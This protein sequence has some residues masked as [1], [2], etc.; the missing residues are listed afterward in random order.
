[1][2]RGAHRDIVVLNAAAGLMVAGRADTMQD[3]VV[4]AAGAIDDGRAASTLAALVATSQQAAADAET[5]A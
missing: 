2:S 5:A 3:A 1:M 4:I